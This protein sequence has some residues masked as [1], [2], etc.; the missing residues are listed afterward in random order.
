M[1]DHPDRRR[2]LGAFDNDKIKTDQFVSIFFSTSHS[3]LNL[4]CEVNLINDMTAALNF[5]HIIYYPSLQW[6]L[7]LNQL[8]RLDGKIRKNS[9]I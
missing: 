5:K 6:I 9:L 1:S 3:N 8:N 4:K 7:A 2:V